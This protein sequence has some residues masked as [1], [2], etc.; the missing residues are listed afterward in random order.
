[1]VQRGTEPLRSAWCLGDRRRL[2]QSCL[3][4]EVFQPNPPPFGRAFRSSV[5]KRIPTGVRWASAHDPDGRARP[6]GRACPSRNQKDATEQ[7]FA[8]HAGRDRGTHLVPRILD[9]VRSPDD[10]NLHRGSVP[11]GDRRSQG[12]QGR[13]GAPTMRLHG[14]GRR[15]GRAQGFRRNGRLRANRPTGLWPGPPGRRFFAHHGAYVKATPFKTTRLA[16]FERAT[17]AR[18]RA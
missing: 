3:A 13:F 17:R 2:R 4:S 8:R 12:H 7:P 9:S 15:L 1:M 14:V 10:D 16:S 6:Q 11:S 18:R 5:F